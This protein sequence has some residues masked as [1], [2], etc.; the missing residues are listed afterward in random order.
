M[1][2]QGRRLYHV[3]LLKE[4]RKL[5]YLELCHVE[6][7]AKKFLAWSQEL[8]AQVAAGETASAWQQHQIRQ[9]LDKYGDVFSDHPGTVQRAEHHI[10][11]T[12][13]QVVRVPL[14]TP[15]YEG[16]SSERSPVH[17]TPGSNREVL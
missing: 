15:S 4:W 11:T 3:N 14:R 16:C 12:Q 13:G 9:V 2:G 6:I 17:V 1:P 5:E 8:Q 7:E 10:P